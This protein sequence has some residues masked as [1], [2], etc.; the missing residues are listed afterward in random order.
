MGRTV[1]MKRVDK[2]LRGLRVLDGRERSYVRG[3]L[4]MF[5]GGGI[6]KTEI[7]RAVSHLKFNKSDPIGT[8]EA[9]RIKKKLLGLF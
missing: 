7:R 1:T 9:N 5:R 6:S 3:L 2:A 8:T 4:S